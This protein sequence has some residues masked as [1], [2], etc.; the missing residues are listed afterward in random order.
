MTCFWS[1]LHTV[2]YVNWPK[3]VTTRWSKLC[4]DESLLKI[5]TAGWYTAVFSKPMVYNTA[6]V[7]TAIFFWYRYTAHPYSSLISFTVS[8]SLHYDFQLTSLSHIVCDIQQKH[9][10]KIAEISY[11]SL[12]CA[13]FYGDTLEFCRDVFCYEKVDFMIIAAIKRQTELQ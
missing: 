11:Y 13:P 1:H 8:L 6:T 3:Y 4:H 7:N 9:L 12:F 10:A 5:S 2:I